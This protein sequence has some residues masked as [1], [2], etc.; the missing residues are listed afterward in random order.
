MTP[1]TIDTLDF[2]SA[3]TAA[4][5]IMGSPD[6][7]PDDLEILPALVA[8]AAAIAPPESA[9]IWERYAEA[10]QQGHLLKVLRVPAVVQPGDPL[11]DLERSF[12][13]DPEI[14]SL[15]QQLEGTR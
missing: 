1:A 13:D 4:R 2:V 6:P 12:S 9:A 10:L 8:R 7:S 15:L 5:T 11:G 3:A 14:A